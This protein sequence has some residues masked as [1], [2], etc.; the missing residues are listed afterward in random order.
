MTE[1]LIHCNA[2]VLHAPGVC[3]YCD[4]LGA[5]RQRARIASHTP[6]TPAEANG[7]AGNVAMTQKMIDD[8]ARYWR[9]VEETW[10]SSKK[11]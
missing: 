9:V 5:D 11:V 2:E 1:P 6:F 8:E 7:W 10:A 4:E 3:I